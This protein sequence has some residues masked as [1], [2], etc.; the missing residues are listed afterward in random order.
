M[1]RNL[2]LI[3]LL[4][5]LII[6]FLWYSSPEQK[7]KRNLKDLKNSFEK[8]NI[9]GVLDKISS[10]FNYYQYKKE[11]AW[12]DCEIFFRYYDNIR[13]EVKE[14]NVK[15][16]KEE[17]ISSFR[18]RVLA[19]YSGYFYILVGGIREFEKVVFY[20]KKDKKKWRIY[21]CRFPTLKYWIL[22]RPEK[23]NKKKKY[24]R[25]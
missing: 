4:T 15:I 24:I 6:Y 7:I 1:R 25:V 20:W 5:I 8:K 14:I 11:D 3:L 12:Q 13:V 18:L 2:L 10:L 19:R 21:D 17:G 16:E 23:F 9:E 22:S